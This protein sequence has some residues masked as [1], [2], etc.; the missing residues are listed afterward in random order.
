MLELLT[1]LIQLRNIRSVFDLAE[2]HIFDTCSR[3]DILSVMCQLQVQYCFIVS[4]FNPVTWS[5][6]PGSRTSPHAAMSPT[7][8]PTTPPAGSL[9]KPTL[10]DEHTKPV[11]P[12]T[13]GQVVVVQH[14]AF[15]PP[16]VEG[17]RL[18]CG[19]ALVRYPHDIDFRVQITSF[20]MCCFDW[21]NCARQNYVYLVLVWFV[22]HT[23]LD[24]SVFQQVVKW[25][26]RPACVL[27]LL[28]GFYG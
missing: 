4:E 24:E 11:N 17:S 16:T 21:F 20:P 19:V 14:S 13:K 6:K 28:I 26:S 12:F 23:L 8:I 22:F 1:S 7:G 2:L 10:L 25:V 9:K 3:G 5:A 15:L 27:M 18:V